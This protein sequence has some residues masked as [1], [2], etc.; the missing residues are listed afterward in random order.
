MSILK[1]YTSNKYNSLPVLIVHESASNYNDGN[2]YLL[3]EYLLRN[4]HHTTGVNTGWYYQI[5]RK[6]KI[7]KYVQ[8]MAHSYKNK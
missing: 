1:K 6:E 3:S 8:F 7:S 4:Y 2:K 5:L